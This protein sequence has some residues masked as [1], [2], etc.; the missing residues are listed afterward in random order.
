MRTAT[1]A[2]VCFVV[3]F[4]CGPTARNN[5]DDT[6]CT[7][8]E[9]RCDGKTVERCVNGSF[10]EGEDCPMACAPDLGC[11]SCVPGTGTCN[12]N[13]SHACNSTGTG[14][15]DVTCDPVQGST[16]DANTGA[17]TGP[18]APQNLGTSYIGCEYYP[19]VTG[20]MVGN[21]YN[22]AVAVAN[23]TPDV[24]N[25]TIEDGGLA[26][27]ITFAV[28]ANSVKVQTLPWQAALKLC[29]GPSWVNCASGVQMDAA[30]AAK[31][32]F[33]LRSTAPVT[34]YQFNPLE[35]SIPAAGEPS[36]TNDASLLLPTNVWRN[37]YF[38]ASWP[39]TQ[40]LNPGL[41]AITARFDGTQVT[42]NATAA[43]GAAQGA[44]AFVANTPQT[45]TLNTGDV[46]EVSTRTGDLTGSRVSTDKPVQVIGGHYCANV[47]LGVAACD[48]I[49]ESM[50][51]VDALG[52]RYIVNA[53]AVTTIPN[54]KVET[55]RII[56]TQ[57]N[58][59]LTY[60]PPQA[61][62]P[63]TIAAAGGYVEIPSTTASFSIE[64]SEKILVAQYMSGQDAG[65]NTGDPDMALAVPIDQFRTSYLFHAPTNYE[66][67]Y[68]DVTAPMGAMVMLDGAPLTFVP[69]GATGF[70]LARVYPLSAGPAGDGNHAMMGTA[71]F[72]ITVYG[73]G[74]YTSYWYPGGLNLTSILE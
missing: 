8:G 7:D 21:V 42:L 45:V 74:Q 43:T 37:E 56:A 27:P 71:A 54:G 4:G 28:P 23:T 41:L 3:A 34:V 60:D 26:A 48:H 14:Y 36:Y 20:N 38:V 6:P 65:G 33:H 69:I 40:G 67:N 1:W 70:G 49:E 61:G 66:S 46:L 35:Y 64:G 16:C 25:V 19:T 44:P 9:L 24:A 51:S 62:A 11:V 12:G 5:G 29:S 17:C 50:F 53:P 31:G 72:G 22:F 73:Y 63:T 55:I 47:P 32:A 15:D 68:V 52:R 58:T 57:P 39:N 13:E 10:E 2:V 18:C 30:Q 59:M